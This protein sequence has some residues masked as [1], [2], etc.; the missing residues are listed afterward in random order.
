MVDTVKNK[1]GYHFSCVVDDSKKFITYVIV[2]EFDDGS[3]EVYTYTL[4]EGE[5]LVTTKPPV[6]KVHAESDG[7][8]VPV[9]SGEWVEG[10]TDAEIAQ[11]NAEHP[12]PE[13]PEP[14]PEE[15]LRADVDFLLAMTL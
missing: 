9:W 14:T 5:S 13:P 7:F 8:I 1:I 15:Q 4:Q 3:E 12:A 10:A 11:F 2:N 6:K